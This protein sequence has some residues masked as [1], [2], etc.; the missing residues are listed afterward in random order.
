MPWPLNFPTS[1]YALALIPLALHTILFQTS[2]FWT[3]IL[4]FYLNKEKIQKFEYVAMALCLLGVALIAIY[5]QTTSIS[6]SKGSLLSTSTIGIVLTFLV[7]WMQAGI[8]VVNRKLKDVHY[9]IITFYHCITAPL[10]AVYLLGSLIVGNSAPIHSAG[11]YLALFAA[12]CFD[13]LQLCSMNIAFQNDSSGFVAILGYISVV[14]G[15]IAD[16]LIFN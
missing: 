1:H 3:S 9:G 10:V 14:Y 6:D 12:C 7:A 2:P 4:G 5:K 15:F 13:F 8:N 16:E 11:I